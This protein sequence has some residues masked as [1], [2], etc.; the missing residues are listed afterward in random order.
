MGYLDNDQDTM[1]AIDAEGYFHTGDMGQL[2]KHGYL[3]ITGRIKELI[4]TAGGENVSPLP[5]ETQLKEACPI[6][7]QAVVI[8]DERKFLTCL[9]TLKVNYDRQLG[10]PTNDLSGEVLS[11]V[12]TLSSKARTVMDAQSDPNVLTFI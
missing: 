11:F 3:E 1:E 4:I 10:R 12:H 7:R 8:G 5:I 2:D 9:F 6:I